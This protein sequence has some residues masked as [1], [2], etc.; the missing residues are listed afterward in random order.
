MNPNQ[1]TKTQKKIFNKILNVWEKRVGKG[2]V[3]D[4]RLVQIIMMAD[5]HGDGKKRIKIDG[6]THLVPI[7]DIMLH[8]IKGTDV[9]NYP[10][11]LI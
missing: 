9:L 7:E 6:E 11:M 10:K 4:K 2:N 3:D 1:M 5:I 8:G